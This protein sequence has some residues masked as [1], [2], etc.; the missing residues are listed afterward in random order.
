MYFIAVV[1]N[2]VWLLTASSEEMPTF[3]HSS[4]VM[5]TM[6]TFAVG[7]SAIEGLYQLFQIIF[8]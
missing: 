6:W 7:V 4:Q 5:A 8:M 2:F 1:A 3:K